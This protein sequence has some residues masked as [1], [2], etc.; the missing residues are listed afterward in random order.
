MATPEI[1]EL[2]KALLAALRVDYFTPGM[3]DVNA[4]RDFLF[5]LDTIKDSAG[6]PLTARDI[7]AAIGLMREQ[8]RDKR[9]GWSLRFG[10]IMR[11][12][13]AFRDL[14]LEARRI[15]RPR[16][17]IQTAQVTQPDG[18]NVMVER[19]PAAEAEPTHVSNP[20]REFRER[21]AKGERS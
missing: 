19:D 5:V 15:K 14:V 9:A 7:H 20:L 13:E 16:K 18:A 2:H 8:N 10:K 17:P 3:G 21:M 4:W 1:L 12:P 6:G 11:E